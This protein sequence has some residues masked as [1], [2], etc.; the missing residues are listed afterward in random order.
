[1][2]CHHAKFQI[3]DDEADL[4]TPVPFEYSPSIAILL[5]LLSTSLESFKPAL[6]SMS[7]LV[8]YISTYPYG[9]RTE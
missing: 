8:H 9:I 2:R 7:P 1:M 4:W 3:L 5:V 6:S